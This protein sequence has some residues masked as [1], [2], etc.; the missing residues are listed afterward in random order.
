MNTLLIMMSEQQDLQLKKNNIIFKNM[1]DNTKKFEVIKTDKIVCDRRTLYRI[2]ALKDF[3][4]VDGRKVYN[5]F[6]RKKHI[7][8]EQIK[9]KYFNGYCML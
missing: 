8:K 6:K 5:S 3:V 4:T 2:G 7:S 9:G 1:A